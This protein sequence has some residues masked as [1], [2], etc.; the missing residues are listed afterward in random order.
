VPV[1]PAF[2]PKVIFRPELSKEQVWS[3]LGQKLRAS[4]FLQLAYAGGSFSGRDSG[5]N[6]KRP[7][8]VDFRPEQQQIVEMVW[9]GDYAHEIISALKLR[10][11][12]FNQKLNE[13]CERLG[14]RNLAL[15]RRS[16]IIAWGEAVRTRG[17]PS[18]DYRDATALPTGRSV[19]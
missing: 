13:I 15:L 9:R 7:R 4:P 19:A 16:L 11:N 18:S 2:D 12:G 17:P 14:A 1:R 6:G 5:C 8:T 3:T 10:V